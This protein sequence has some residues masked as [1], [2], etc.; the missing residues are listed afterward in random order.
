MLKRSLPI[1]FAAL[2]ASAQMT[3]IAADRI[4]AHVKFLSSDLLEGRGVG[5]RG[6]Q[7]ATEYIAAGFALAGAKPAGDNGTYFQNFTLIG[8]DPQPESRLTATTRDGRTLSF[9]WLDD[10][11]GLTLQQKPDSAFDADAVFVGHGI[12][13]PEYGWDDYAGADVNGKVVVMFTNEPPSDDPKFFGGRALTYYGR[14][15]YKYEEATRHGA[16]AAIIIHTTPTASY[17]WDVVRSSWGREDQQVKLAP[18]ESALAFAGWVTEPQGDKIAAT[19]GKTA[20][21]LLAMADTRGFRPI[22][23]PLRFHGVMPAKIREIHTRNVIGKVEGSDPQLQNEAVIFSA[24]WD[25][26]GI[27]A[28][29]NGDSIYNGAADNATGCAMLLEI[30]RAWAMLPEKP[31][32][33]ALFLAVSAEEAGLRGSEYYGEHPVIPAGKT[34]ADLNFDMFMPFG[35][36]SDVIVNGAERTT[37]YPLVEEAARRFDLAIDP[38]PR[39]SAGTYYR[40]DHFSLARVGIPSFSIEPGENLLGKPPGAGHQLFEDFNEHHYHQPSDEYHDDWDFS[41]MEQFARFGF[42]IGLNAANAPK[43]ATWHAGDEFLPAR[44]ASGVK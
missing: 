44:I 22:A 6:G 39:P 24:H 12:T 14:W 33:S 23:L 16:V 9:R 10:F 2:A 17:G 18:N 26:L 28:P 21:Q 36:S 13:A 37:L 34:M 1:L 31:R 29:V 35:R 27:G 30:A 7:I 43:L 3:E 20:A 8:A 25:H 32:R 38:D 5:T 15:T 41:G 40:S 42:L 11:V 19:I 4:R